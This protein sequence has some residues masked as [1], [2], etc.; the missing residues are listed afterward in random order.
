MAA[1]DPRAGAATR[2]ITL[3]G[4]LDLRS[5]FGPLARGAGDPTMRVSAGA[6]I[7]ASVTPDGPG[8]IEV[9]VD[10]TSVRAWAWGP[11]AEQ[12][13]DG[14]PAALGLDDDDDGFDPALHP[15]VAGLAR[16]FGRVRLARTGAVW[17][18]LLPAILEQRITGTEAWRNYRRLVRAHGA[19]APG[20]LGVLLPPTAEA[21]AGLPSWT[22]TG[23]GVEPRRGAVLRRIARECPRLETLGGPARLPG[24]GGAGAG[25]LVAALRAHAGIGPWTAAEV[26]LRALGDP[27][28]VSV[29]DAHLS[30]VVTFALTGA[31]RG[32][33]EQMLELLAP[34]A[35][36]RARVVRLIEASGIRPPRYGPRVAPRDLVRD[37]SPDARLPVTPRG[38]P[39]GRPSR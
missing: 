7:R 10:G 29:G 11:G 19:P 26:T 36:H 35:G 5:A 31:P 18:S 9:R 34:W 39:R 6:A 13:L 14:L 15:V 16:R 2:A 23:L 27:D 20:P 33:D 28:A 32:T 8:A 21:V 3:D 1:G 4:R 17:E 24:G 12:L 37:F 22:L 38:G 25:A 30:N